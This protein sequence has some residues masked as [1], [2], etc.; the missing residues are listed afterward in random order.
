MIKLIDIILEATTPS[1]EAKRLGLTYM[2]FGRW[3]KDGV[4]THKSVNG[5]LQPIKDKSSAQPKSKKKVAAKKTA[6]KKKKS[7]PAKSQAQTP[8]SDTSDKHALTSKTA[9]ALTDAIAKSPTT[10]TLGQTVAKA[11]GRSTPIK[12]GSYTILQKLQI[13][14]QQ[15]TK[16]VTVVG[17]YDPKKDELIFTNKNMNFSEPPSEWYADTVQNFRTVIH[18]SIHSSSPRVKSESILTN[19]LARIL[20]EGLTEAL[21]VDTTNSFLKR[22]GVNNMMY[23]SNPYDDF[24][25]GIKY[26][27]NSSDISLQD[28]HATQT[29]EELIKMVGASADKIVEEKLSQL[30]D[31]D[32]IEKIKNVI[33]QTNQ[34]VVE[35]GFTFGLGLL[36]PKI[37]D[38]TLAITPGAKSK[39][40]ILSKMGIDDNQ[41]KDILGK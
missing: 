26:I 11:M 37:L 38:A 31:T 21:T 28:M 3:G 23:Y 12:F 36:D 19:P 7:T 27:S 5:K 17:G 20:E 18:E 6:L 41:I 25:R 2:S 13:F 29:P 40:R 9:D 30:F 14:R 39:T 15:R 4:V 33:V 1:D 32:Q 10:E 8:S 35:H 34:N 22:N 24:R 16:E